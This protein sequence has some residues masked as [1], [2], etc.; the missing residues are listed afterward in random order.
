[1]LARRPAVRPAASSSR[2][3]S[4]AKLAS[5]RGGS[6]AA[7]LTARSAA[8]PAAA[9]NPRLPALLGL[10]PSLEGQ[11][12]CALRN[13]RQL[14]LDLLARLAVVLLLEMDLRQGQVDLG[15]PGI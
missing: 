8:R 11:R 15:Q 10:E 4:G 3:S 6:W 2:V 13:D 12:P 9:G 1:M 5:G 7:A 14:A